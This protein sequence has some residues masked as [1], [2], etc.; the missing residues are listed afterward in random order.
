MAGEPSVE[1]LLGELY[2]GV[3]DPER[4]ARF[5]RLATHALG[6]H[7]GAWTVRRD[8]VR[9]ANALTVEGAMTPDDLRLRR[10][11]RNGASEDNLWYQRARPFMTAGAVVDGDTYATTREVKSTRY[12]AELLRDIDTLHSLAVCASASPGRAVVLS[13]C[14]SGS[15]G[16]YDPIHRER[17]NFIAP[18]VAHAYRL[19]DE[20]ARIASGASHRSLGIELDARLCPVHGT[21]EAETLAASGWLRVAPQR[22]VEP[23]HTVS[24]A[25]WRLHCDHHRARPCETALPVPLYDANDETVGLMRLTQHGLFNPESASKFICRIALLRFPAAPD[26]TEALRCLFK[27]TPSEARLAMALHGATDL[28]GA[29][30]TL[31]I[32]IETARSRLKAIYAKTGTHRQ[33][34]LA[35]LIDALIDQHR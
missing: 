13:F 1:T 3:W 25:L 31:G 4:L 12:Y 2:A 26:V 18:H 10:Y 8:T 20:R 35:A 17:A 15:T 16:G 11:G 22:P 14:R 34:T 30:A 23:V 5:T 33:A 29:A 6:S 7:T 32:S 28:V 9:E 24:R 19:I 21:V 27:L